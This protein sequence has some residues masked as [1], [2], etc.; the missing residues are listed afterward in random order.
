MGYVIKKIKE[1]IDH[2]KQE[3]YDMQDELET[4]V[5]QCRIIRERIEELYSQNKELEYALYK[6]DE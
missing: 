2:N 1:N 4:H 6:L 3:I 5:N